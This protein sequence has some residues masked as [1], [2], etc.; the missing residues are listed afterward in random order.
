MEAIRSRCRLQNQRIPEGKRMFPMQQDCRHNHVK[1]RS[2][3]SETGHVLH[4]FNSVF[5]R[6]RRLN[7]RGRHLEEFLNYL[8][9]YNAGLFTDM[10]LH[11]LPR[12]IPLFLQ[13][14]R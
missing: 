11:E 9:T 13:F 3:D 5:F 12:N 6:D 2:D 8:D 7:L 1:I 10:S 4:E 14:D